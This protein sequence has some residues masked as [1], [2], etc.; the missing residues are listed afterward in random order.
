MSQ[1]KSTVRPGRIYEY[2]VMGE[3]MGMGFDLYPAAADDQGIDA[4]L[5]YPTGTASAKYF[6]VQI[7]GS[8]NWAGIRCKTAPYK[9]RHNIILICFC[10]SAFKKGCSEKH[11][12]WFSHEDLEKLFGFKENRKYGNIFFQEKAEQTISFKKMG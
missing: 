12:A 9:N 11:L 4:I 2:I 8:W 10:Y 6:E 1:A 7:K 3:M 5:R